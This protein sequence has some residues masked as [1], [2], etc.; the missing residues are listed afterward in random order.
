LTFKVGSE[1]VLLQSN[2]LKVGG[3]GKHLHEV[4]GKAPTAGQTTLAEVL[5]LQEAEAAIHMAIKEGLVNQAVSNAIQKAFVTK[6]DK[7]VVT[8]PGFTWE[9]AAEVAVQGGK[10]FVKIFHMQPL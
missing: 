3:A 1:T 2:A 9:I 7:L 5:V 8:T 6:L 10:R 4:L